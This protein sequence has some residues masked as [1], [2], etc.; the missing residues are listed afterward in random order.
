MAMTDRR[1]QLLRDKKCPIHKIE[2]DL[3]AAGNFGSDYW[4]SAPN[5]KMSARFSGDGQFQEINRTASRR[6]KS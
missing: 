1:L 5:C 2:M 6:G 3:V 4:C